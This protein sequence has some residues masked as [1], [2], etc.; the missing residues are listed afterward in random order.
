MMAPR[1]RIVVM[2]GRAARPVFPNGPFYV[3]GLTLS[4][5]V[6]FAC[7][8]EE[9]RACANDMN[10]WMASGRLKAVIGKDFPLSDAAKAHALQE[11]NTAGSTGTLTGKIVVLPQA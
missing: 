9:Q 11:E 4:G 2:A 7:T 3:K 8:A 6:M 5:F 10:A 1:G